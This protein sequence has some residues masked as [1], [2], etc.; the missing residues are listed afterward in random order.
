MMP[1]S[2]AQIYAEHADM[3]LKL[4]EMG[5]DAFHGSEH[6]FSYDSFC[7][8]PLVGLAQVARRTK[9]IKLVTCALL[10]PLHDPLSV[11]RDA[12]TLDRISNG[13]VILGLGMGYRPNEFDGLGS[14]K[15]TRGARLVEMTQFLSRAL[16]G[17]PC[18]YESKHYKYDN[19]TL[20]P[21]PVQHKN[22]PLLMC[23]GTSAAAARRAGRAGL[24]Y[25]VVNTNYER[26]E[27]CVLAYRE[28]GRKAGHPPEVLKAAVFK[29]FCLAA[30]REEAL[31]VREFVMSAFYDEHIL[32][33]GYLVDEEGNH[34]Y[35]PPRTHPLYKRFLGAICTDTPDEAIKEVAR[36]QK[37]GIDAMY[38]STGQ[39][40]LFA[41]EVLPAF[42]KV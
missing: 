20:R 40:E 14:E 42:K 16:T 39:K 11:A 4:E 6:H 32:G 9:R 24:P 36:Y 15:R 26:A 5:F 28:E 1:S 27:E 33:F 18:S 23:G 3:A 30:T 13:R 25:W 7:P 8:S 21:K 19:I 34:L 2:L 37:L 10:L 12:A 41:K 31:K 29:D 38:V 35:N 17:E 22:F